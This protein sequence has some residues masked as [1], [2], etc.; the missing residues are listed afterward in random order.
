MTHS[1]VIYF[2]FKIW[3]KSLKINYEIKIIS[4][5]L[6]ITFLNILHTIIYRYK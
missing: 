5:L 3:E 4:N 6:V 2:N 1:F